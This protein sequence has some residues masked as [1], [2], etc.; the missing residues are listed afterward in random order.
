MTA[1]ERL[2]GRRAE[3]E[4]AGLLRAAGFTVRGLES[5]GDHHAVRGGLRLHVEV[6]RQERGWRWAWAA[7][8]V[9]DAPDGSVPVVVFRRSREPWQVARRVAS[10][11]LIRALVVPPGGTVYS[12]DPRSNA[13]WAFCTLA[14]FLARVEASA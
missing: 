12:V 8:A 14:A 3:A 7:Q 5:G 11:E 6:K 2:K 13:G 4:V 10:L 9:A 1:A